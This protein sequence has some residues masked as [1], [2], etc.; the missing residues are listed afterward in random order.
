MLAEYAPIT[1]A[2]D[3]LSAVYLVQG[4]GLLA[5]DSFIMAAVL[6]KKIPETFPLPVLM[7]KL[8]VDFPKQKVILQPNRGAALILPQGYLYQTISSRCLKEYPLK[9]VQKLVTTALTAEAQCQTTLAQLQAGLERMQ[10]FIFGSDLDVFLDFTLKE[11][12]GTLAIKLPQGAVTKKVSL[13]F[14]EPVALRWP[15]GPVLR[16]VTYVTKLERKAM[17]ECGFLSPFHFLR[18]QIQGR[19][20]LLLMA[21]AT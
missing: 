20:Y 16:W 21:E 8:L 19:Q 1:A 9:T 18:C 14:C 12:V 2:A 4:Q 6:D 7:A 17:V 13:S 11:N 10:A 5:T 3:H 15:A